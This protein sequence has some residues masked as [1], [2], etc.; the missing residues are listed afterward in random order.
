MLLLATLLAAVVLSAVLHLQHCSHLY[1]STAIAESRLA[2]SCFS[3]AELALAS[4][5]AVAGSLPEDQRQTVSAPL[6]KKSNAVLKFPTW[7]AQQRPASAMQQLEFQW[8]LPLQEL[9]AAIETHLDTS[10]TRGV[11]GSSHK[12]QGRDFSPMLE[13][14]PT[15]SAGEPAIDLGAFVWVSDLAEGSMC[16]VRHKLEIAACDSTP[17]GRQQG[18]RQH[19]GVG[20]SWFCYK[21]GQGIGYPKLV[22]LGNIGTWA[23]AEAKL[24]ELGLVHS[25]GCVHM[26]ITVTHVE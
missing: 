18:A 17:A 21:S 23:A 25:D 2:Q 5:L 22:K 15:A 8:L 9:Q 26:T 3:P 7:T 19:T 11:Y 1:I 16:R 24:R 20:P 10:K 6:L 13:V 4:I 12:W 14:W